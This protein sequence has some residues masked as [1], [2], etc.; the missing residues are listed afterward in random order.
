MK[1]IA[2][3]L[4][5]TLLGAALWG[6]STGSQPPAEAPD[7]AEAAS[8]AKDVP[9]KWSDDMTLEQKAEFMKAHVAPAMTPVFADYEDGVE[10][11]CATCHGPD[12][13]L[14][15]EFLPRL[16]FENGN[17]TSFVEE[18]EESQFMAERVVPAM[19]QA[20][21]ME[22]YN[23]ETGKGFGCNGCHAIDAGE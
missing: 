20:L 23:V 10:L 12:N 9:A 1:A 21:G 7:E 11:T 15:T 14:P 19:A 2:F 18:P 6:C 22:P 8:E 4:P 17:I 13:K 5:L 16:R 3:A